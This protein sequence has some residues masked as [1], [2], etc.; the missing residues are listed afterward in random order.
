MEALWSGRRDHDV[1]VRQNPT[2]A[3]LRRRALSQLFDHFG[4]AMVPSEAWTAL[5]E[6]EDPVVAFGQFAAWVGCAPERVR[7]NDASQ[8]ARMQ[9][10]I[11]LL[12]S[13]H[14]IR[15]HL[16]ATGVHRIRSALAFGG[17][18]ALTDQAR[19]VEVLSVIQACRLRAEGLQPCAAYERFANLI[20][21]ECRDPLATALSE[22]EEAALISDRFLRAMHSYT[23]SRAKIINVAA[24]IAHAWARIPGSAR[25]VDVRDGILFRAEDFDK[26]LGD[27]GTLGVGDVENLADEC[28]ILFEALCDI[29]RR[30]ASDTDPGADDPYIDEREAG[31]KFFGFRPGSSP[32]EGEIKKIFREMWK[33]HNVDDPSHR[34]TESQRLE[35]EKWLKDIN[36]YYSVLRSKTGRDLK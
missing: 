8:L 16:S 6:A 29:Y 10:A 20:D 35:N 24:E 1:A 11:D 2:L 3:L 36:K 9:T 26:E 7:R 12:V 32:T 23:D 13:L 19:Q 21:E 14:A 30:H 31:L 22:I 5:D 4:L 34:T 18:A 17:D 27:N 33:K 28:A 25:D 15:V